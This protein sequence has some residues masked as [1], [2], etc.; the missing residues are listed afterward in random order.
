MMN[1]NYIPKILLIK[2]INI[3]EKLPFNNKDKSNCE[4]KLNEII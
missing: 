3:F 1:I 2:T 4:E